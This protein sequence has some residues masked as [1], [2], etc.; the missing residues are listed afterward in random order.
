LLFGTDHNDKVP[1]DHKEKSA[2]FICDNLNH[3]G[4]GFLLHE[5][6]DKI[7]LDLL[8]I[9]SWSI[10]QSLHAKTDQFPNKDSIDVLPN[11]QDT[12]AMF[13]AVL[14]SEDRGEIAKPTFLEATCNGQLPCTSPCQE[15]DLSKGEVEGTIEYQYSLIIPGC[16]PK[17]H[18]KHPLINRTGYSGVILSDMPTLLAYVEYMLC[19]HAWCHDSH[20]LCIELQQDHDLIDLGS[21]MLVQYFDSILYR[22]DDTCDTDTCES[23]TQLHNSQ[24][25]CYF[26]DLMQYSTAMGEC[27]LKLWA[28]GMSQM[29]LK[30]G[31]DKFTCST[32]SC[33]GKSMVLKTI[34]NQLQ[35]Q[36]NKEQEKPFLQAC[37]SKR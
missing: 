1:F 13:A 19:Y 17:H 4:F 30:Q 34:T 12:Q 29:A 3:H 21:K 20:L 32:S 6:L 11:H 25:H 9:A 16:V 15:I 31:I 18:R 8:M 10:L 33:I 27:G 2:E 35:I 22:G 36:H 24:S 7:Q 14:P 28:K 5:D 23:H 37:I 26:S